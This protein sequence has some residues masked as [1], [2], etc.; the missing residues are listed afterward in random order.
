MIV[1]NRPARAG[2]PATKF[3]FKLDDISIDNMVDKQ[4]V[5]G[6]LQTIV[7]NLS[8]QADGHS[9]QS[10]VFESCGYTKLA[11]K[12]AEH[13][14]EE[15]AYIDRCVDRI[16]DIGGFV[17]NGAKMET[18]IFKDPVEWIKYDLVVSIEGLAELEKLLPVI[19]DDVTTYD[20]IKAY[21]MDEEEDMRWSEQQLGLINAI[22]LQNWLSKQF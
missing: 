3:I 6:A 22:G 10:R 14:A 7:T 8:Q 16:L 9:I 2:G 1:D 12:Y 18:P 5:I 13:A 17:T 19:H 4:T 15:R 21:Y 20:L 11:E